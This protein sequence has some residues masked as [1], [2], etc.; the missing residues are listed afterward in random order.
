MF[1][2]KILLL[3]GLV[4]LLLMTGLAVIHSKYHS[5]LLFIE[6]QKQEAM[7]DSYELAWGQRQLELTTLTEENRVEEVATQRLKLRMPDRKK[8]IFLKL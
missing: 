1:S 5:R 2:Y 8:I 3:S 7:L 4:L 6:I